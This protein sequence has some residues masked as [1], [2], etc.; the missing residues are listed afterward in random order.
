MAKDIYVFIVEDKE[1]ADKIID[2]VKKGK[3]TYVSIFDE[4][5]RPKIVKALEE[6]GSSGKEIDKLANFILEN[7][8]D[9]IRDESAVDVAIR[10]LAKKQK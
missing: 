7:Y 5:L 9:E 2:E 8:A 3:A 6:V 10:L 1:L 4:K